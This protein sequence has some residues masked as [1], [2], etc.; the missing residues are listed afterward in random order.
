MRGS[1]P[2]ALLVASWALL[3]PSWGP[4]GGPLG[5]LLGGLLGPLGP[6]W[7]PLGTL[8]GVL[9]PAGLAQAFQ[10]L[11]RPPPGGGVVPEI[12]FF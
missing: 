5:A 1:P 3:G 2:G 8:L 6:S 11:C 4:L 12:C 9:G 7:G 10:K